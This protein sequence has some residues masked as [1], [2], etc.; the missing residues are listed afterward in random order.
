MSA[1]GSG[2]GFFSNFPPLLKL[3]EAPLSPFLFPQ[4]AEM[5][6]MPFFENDGFLERVRF[7]Q[8]L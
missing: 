5:A 7:H 2:T 1:Y 4:T 3:S 8:H 6:S